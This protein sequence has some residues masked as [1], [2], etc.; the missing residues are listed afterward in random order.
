[1]VAK[2]VVVDENAGTAIV[3]LPD[4]WKNM[5]A[6]QHQAESSERVLIV[7][8]LQRMKFKVTYERKV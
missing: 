2:R 7:D 4:D 6:E 3:Y 1:M 8:E 5:S